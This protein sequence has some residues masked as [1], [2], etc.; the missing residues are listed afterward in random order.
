MINLA[1]LITERLASGVLPNVTPRSRWAGYGRSSTC[2]GCDLP[3]R[4]D[5][6][7][8]EFDFADDRRIRLHR[9]CANEWAGQTSN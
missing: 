9:D 7:E 4:A 2:D 5:Q 3:I 1:A 8:D 6:I